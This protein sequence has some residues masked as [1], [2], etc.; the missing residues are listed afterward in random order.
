M[1]LSNEPPDHKPGVFERPGVIKAIV[2]ALSIVCGL[3]I[4]AEFFYVKH[5]HFGFDGWFAFY[6]AFGFGAY[7]LIV[8]GAKALRPLLWRGE[9]YYHEADVDVSDIDPS[10]S[11]SGSHRRD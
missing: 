7:C 3:L 4:L 5:P 9:N 8:L 10:E 1:T 2:V 6:P 11:S